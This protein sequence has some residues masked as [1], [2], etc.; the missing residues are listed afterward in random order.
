MYIEGVLARSGSVCVLH[1]GAVANRG[2]LG[3]VNYGG[4]GGCEGA[5]GGGGRA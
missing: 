1:V 2:K 3:E 4:G 5:R